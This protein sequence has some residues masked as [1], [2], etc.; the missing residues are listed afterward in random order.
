M[1]N[2]HKHFTE[3]ICRRN[4]MVM[5]NSQYEKDC[6]EANEV[7]CRLREL[8]KDNQEAC[9]LLFELD[10]LEGAIHSDIAIESYE[11]GFYDGL[12]LINRAIAS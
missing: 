2:L 5:P 6:H 10:S 1:E 4:E 11:K 3:F 9:K 12:K 8:I 7:Y